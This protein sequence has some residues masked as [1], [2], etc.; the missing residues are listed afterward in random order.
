MISVDMISLEKTVHRL[1]ELLEQSEEIYDSSLHS[2]HILSDMSIDSADEEMQD[3]LRQLSEVK[4]G[5]FSAFTKLEE[6]ISLYC[7]CE[8]SVIETV[9]D[10]PCNVSSVTL[11]DTAGSLIN[12]QRNT[13]RPHFLSLK[14]SVYSGH[15]VQNEDWLE[16]MIFDRRD[17]FE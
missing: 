15:S 16:K 8:N 13:I 1:T 7:R 6:I 12:S 4:E 3:A 17:S 9:R 2:Y 11:K 14:S 5:I 10:L